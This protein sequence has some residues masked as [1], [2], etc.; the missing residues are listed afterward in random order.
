L[1]TQSAVKKLYKENKHLDKLWIFYSK[2]LKMLHPGALAGIF[3]SL[4]FLFTC[5]FAIWFA[6]TRRRQNEAS[7]FLIYF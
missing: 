3:F 4:M 7:E 2:S 5:A 6:I 1:I